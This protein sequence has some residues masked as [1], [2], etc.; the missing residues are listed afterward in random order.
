MN[1][2]RQFTLFC[3]VVVLAVVGGTCYQLYQASSVQLLSPLQPL[4][5]LSYLPFTAVKD[6]TALFS[7]VVKSSVTILDGESVR[8][9]GFIVEQTKDCGKIVTAK[10]VCDSI[11]LESLNVELYD[12]RVF[13][14]DT[15]K[16][17]D[18]KL[19][20]AVLYIKAVNL[21]PIKLGDSSKVKPGQ[22]AFALGAPFGFKYSFTYGIVSAVNRTVSVDSELYE[23]MIQIDT[24]V[25]PGNSG[26]LVVDVS[27]RLIGMTVIGVV[28]ADGISF[29]IPVDQIKAVLEVK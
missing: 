3:A 4:P 6:F 1:R 26:G 19:D 5:H 11:D 14:V 29:A 27:G 25:N 17:P 28:N 10:H 16:I 2:I 18:P 23:G 22:Y 20:I 24:P 15:L 21:T 12:G 13:K 8:G 9:A 7:A